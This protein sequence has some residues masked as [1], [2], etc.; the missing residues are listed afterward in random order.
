MSATGSF[1]HS[2]QQSSTHSQDDTT[3]FVQI[4]EL[5]DVEIYYEE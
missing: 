5:N 2:A 3:E 4:E 1:V